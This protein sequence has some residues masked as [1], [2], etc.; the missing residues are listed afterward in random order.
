M[1]PNLVQNPLPKPVYDTIFLIK[2]SVKTRKNKRHTVIFS[3]VNIDDDPFSGKTQK[4]VPKTSEK[5]KKFVSTE[6]SF[7]F[8]HKSGPKSTA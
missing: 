8:G 2:D 6:K 4:K 3:K 7:F 1:D 5:Q